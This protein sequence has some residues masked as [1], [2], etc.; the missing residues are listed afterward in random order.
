MMAINDLKD[1][2][3]S[4]LGQATGKVSGVADRAVG[5]AKS[6]GRMAKLAMDAATAREDVK[7]TYLEI[8]KLYYDTHK[9]DPEGFF[10][11]LFEEVRIAEEDIAAKEAELGALRESLKN[12]PVPASEDG[13]GAFERAVDAVEEDAAF[14]ETETEA[15]AEEKTAADLAGEVVED[16]KDARDAVVEKVQG[17]WDAVVEKAETVQSV[18]VEKIGSA[19]DAVSAKIAE[20]RADAE[21]AAEEI[22]GEAEV[23]AE[24]AE[25]EDRQ[26]EKEHK[27]E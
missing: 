26:A 23:I 7:R 12:G 3:L 11:Q 2:V 10:V 4:A 8:G 24:A 1:A 5:T 16:V 21:E 27:D 19:A 6:G 17:I 22:A 9:D 15:E 20:V 18:V 25:E 13:G 14:A